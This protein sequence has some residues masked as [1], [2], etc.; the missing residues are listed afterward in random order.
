[1]NAWRR[2]WRK[3]N[4]EKVR[5]EKK[6]YRDAHPDKEQAKKLRWIKKHPA[7]AKASQARRSA[8]YSIKHREELQARVKAPAD[9][10][11]QQIAYKDKHPEKIRES[12]R[13]WRKRHAHYKQRI[14]LAGRPR[15]DL[16][17]ACGRHPGDRI[18]VF[19]HSHT[20]GHFRGWLC[21]RCNMALGLVDDNPQILVK[22]IAYLKR[23]AANTSPQLALPV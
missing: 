17:E 14:S 4:P 19:D 1:M 22:L 5:A 10:R 8:R 18:L 6:A 7:L 9:Q 21:H 2:A 20:K 23:T 11:A 15:P 12:E 3:A 13:A 16:C